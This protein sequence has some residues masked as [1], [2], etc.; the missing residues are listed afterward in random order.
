MNEHEGV[1]LW[2]KAHL[3]DDMLHYVHVE[4]QAGDQAQPPASTAPEKTYGTDYSNL[5]E[6]E[7]IIALAADDETLPD[8]LRTL[9]VDDE[10][11]NAY[12]PTGAEI[13]RLREMFETL[14]HGSA[15]AY[16]AALYWIRKYLG[17]S[18]SNVA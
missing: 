3:P 6:R 4:K 13:N 15:T 14:G 2:L 16:C 12:K 11:W 8:G 7:E 10:F 17:S 5:A 18:E 1:L 9:I